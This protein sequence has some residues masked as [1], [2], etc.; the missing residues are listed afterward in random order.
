MDEQINEQPPME[1]QPI[2]QPQVE[3]KKGRLMI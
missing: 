2:E 1:Q 3:K